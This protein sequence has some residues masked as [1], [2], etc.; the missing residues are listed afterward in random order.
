MEHRDTELIAGVKSGDKAALD[1]LVRRWYPQIY[2]YVFKLVAHEQDAYDITQDVFVAMLQ[3]IHTFYPWRK[4]QSWLF[5]IAHNKCMDYFRLQKR[6]ISG[7]AIDLDKPA[8]SP[9]LDDLVTASVSVKNALAQLS[10]VQREAI[11]LFYFYQ[12]TA[13]EI[14]HMTHAPLPTVKSRLSSAKRSLAKLLREDFV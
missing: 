2:G 11:I 5:T 6:V 3:N 8:P 14:S 7:E 10:A 13:K 4:F 12:F 9:S 1:Q